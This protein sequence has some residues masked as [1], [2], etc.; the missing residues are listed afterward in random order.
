MSKR[1]LRSGHSMSLMKKQRYSGDAHQMGKIV[2][3]RPRCGR[4]SG[5]QGAAP[6]AQRATPRIGAAPGLVVYNKEGE[7]EAGDE[8]KVVWPYRRRRQWRRWTKGK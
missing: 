8:M 1:R 7:G 3:V 2:V 5:R 4:R 6:I